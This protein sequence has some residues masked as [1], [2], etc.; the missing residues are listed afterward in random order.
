MK[1]S[2]SFLDGASSA[3]RKRIL[4]HLNAWG[5]RANVAFAQTAGVG[6]VRIARLD[7][8]AKVAGFWSYIGTE[9]LEI[10]MG[11]GFDRPASPDRHEGWRLDHA[12]RCADLAPASVPVTRRP[13]E[14]KHFFIIAAG[15]H[16]PGYSPLALLAAG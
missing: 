11:D 16:P 9:I 5:R 1:L 10:A 13:G 14:A 4:L 6:Q 8:P 15:P 2:V 7:H 3:L 12:V